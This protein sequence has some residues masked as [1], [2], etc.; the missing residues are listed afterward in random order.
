MFS[1]AIPGQSDREPA[2]VDGPLSQFT[3]SR[4]LRPE[5]DTPNRPLPAV[6]FERRF[7]TF[8]LP[9]CA[10]RSSGSRLEYAGIG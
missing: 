4:S 2:Y 8:H 6:M 9:G 1:Q 5:T 10:R 7:G 3:G